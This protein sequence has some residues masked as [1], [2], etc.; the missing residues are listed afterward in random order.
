[1]VVNSVHTL[2]TVVALSRSCHWSADFAAVI[3]WDVVASS[4]F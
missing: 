2:T 1:M 3:G 4:H